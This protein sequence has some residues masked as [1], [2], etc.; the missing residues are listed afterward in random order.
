MLLPVGKLTN[1][2]LAVEKAPEIIE[3]IRMVWLGS[4]YPSRG[5]Y[6]QDN[7]TAS[8]NYLLNTDVHFEMVTVRYGK[9]S[10][11]DAVKVIMEDIKANMPGKGP[12]AEESVEGRHGNLFKT[13]GDYSMNLFKNCQFHGDPPTRSLFDLAAVAIVKNPSWAEKS[14]IPA[15]ILVDNSWKERPNNPR[16]IILWEHF[17]RDAIVND[18]FNR[19]ENYVLAGE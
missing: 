13:F 19:M 5:E 3:N 14:T 10:G 4:N 6:N 17:D 12:V 16:E 1:M 11:T 2:A 15:P 8:M 9:P 7:D 18:L